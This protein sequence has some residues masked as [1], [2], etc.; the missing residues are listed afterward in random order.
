[1]ISYFDYQDYYVKEH[2]WDCVYDNDF[3]GVKVYGEG[4]S[5]LGWQIFENSQEVSSRSFI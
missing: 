3:Y 1:M 5:L 4:N 2:R